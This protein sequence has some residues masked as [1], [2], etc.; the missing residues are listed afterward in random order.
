M[1]SKNKKINLSQKVRKILVKMPV[2]PLYADMQ[3]NT[4]FALQKCVHADKK[5]LNEWIVSK[6]KSQAQYMLINRRE[7]IRN[8]YQ[9]Y[10]SRFVSLTNEIKGVLND[11][12]SLKRR[13]SCRRLQAPHLVQLST[14][15]NC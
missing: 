10:I 13:M 8:E 2:I 5:V 6:E 4:Q 1:C 7:V 9:I 3:I 11:K 15:S 12:N 14:V